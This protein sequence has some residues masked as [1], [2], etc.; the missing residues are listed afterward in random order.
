LEDDEAYKDLYHKNNDLNTYYV[1]AFAGRNI[2]IFLR[3]EGSYTS[4]EIND[5]KFYILYVIF[6][7]LTSSVYPSNKT[8][9]ALTKNL[10]TKELLNTSTDIVYD[11]YKALGGS[12]KVAKG[13]R[14]I[15]MVKDKLREKKV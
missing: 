6:A 10:I 3:E 13:S 15:E 11:L 1:L 8:I 9:T 5:I 4:S 2:E 14:L 12:D 7:Q